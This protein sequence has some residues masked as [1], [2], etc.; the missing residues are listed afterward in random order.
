MAWSS[1]TKGRYSFL[2]PIS[3]LEGLGLLEADVS[4]KKQPKEV[5]QH[6]SFFQGPVSQ[7]PLAYSALLLPFMHLQKLI[8]YEIP[9]Q[10]QFQFSFD[11]HWVRLCMLKQY[12]YIP[13][14]L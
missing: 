1:P 12:L 3:G 11:F 7:R 10:I 2:Q 9:H 6:L 14:G 4:S 8:S 5:I 13:P